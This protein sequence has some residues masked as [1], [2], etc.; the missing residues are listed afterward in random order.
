[1]LVSRGARVSQYSHLT[2]DLSNPNSPATKIARLVGRGRLV[3]DVGCAHGYLAEA[4]RAQDCHVIGIEIDP[5]DAARARTHCEQVVV[6]DV[7]EPGWLDELRERHFDV[8]VFADV[9][10]HLRNPARVLR[11][12]RGLLKP[13]SGYIV[14]SVPNV[15]HTS[16]RLELLLGSFRSE[17]VGILDA[18]HL[19]F[20]TRDTLD[21]L[22]ASCGFAVD[23]WD[24]TTN[25]IGDAVIAD[26]LQRAGLAYTPEL[27]ERFVEF[28][29]MAYQFIITARPTTDTTTSLSTPITKPLQVMQELIAGHERL[30]RDHERLTRDHQRLQTPPE[31]LEEPREG[32]LRVLQVIHQ[33]LPRHA[34]GT[35][36]YC[37]DL[38]FGLAR[39]GHAVRIL[40]GAPF[41]E[42]I[43]TSVQ[44]EGDTGIVVERVPATRTYRLLGSAGGFVDRFDNPEARAAIRSVLN[45]MRPDVVHV[46]HL[47][48]LSAELIPECRNRGIPV[49]VTLHDYWFL[50]HRIRLERPDGSLCDGPARGW[51]CCQCLNTARLARS[52][53]NPAAVTA[54]LYR[55]AYLTRQLNKVDRILAPSQF[56]RDVFER[57]GLPPGRVTVCHFGISGPPADGG[58]LLAA[59]RPHERVRFGYLGSLMHHKG[60]HGLIDAFNQ[61][62]AGRAELHVFGAAPDPAYD[63]E[64]RRR[65]LHPDIHWHGKIP[66]ASRWRAL[67]EVDVLVVPSIWYENSPLTILEALVARVPI[68]GAAIGGIPEFVRNG[69]NGLTYPPGDVGALAACLRQVLDDPACVPRWQQAITPPRS[70]D[71]HTDEIEALY[72]ELCSARARPTASAHRA[73]T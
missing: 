3:L 21:E 39:R 2:A 52:H 35:E 57:N 13:G 46:Q 32:G 24:C 71:A 17:P 30:T 12:V 29:A 36:I 68:I 18:T 48:Y 61:L 22:L 8:I 54:N 59:P 65:A 62:P 20:Y 45:R 27:R 47:L 26:Y 69:V 49:V 31:A 5:E 37:S 34:A 28:E 15:A 70:T 63:Q 11:E 19:H 9:L 72:R 41:L 43:G 16:V 25:E 67:G 33:F 58:E 73:S 4:L 1:L 66:H 40:S 50:C 6:R 55:Y 44:W 64:L 60:V 51:N 38:S 14:A 42:D 56:L 7:E 10:E 53:L 23:F